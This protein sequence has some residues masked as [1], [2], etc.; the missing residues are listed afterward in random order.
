MLN[1]SKKA[2]PNNDKLLNGRRRERLSEIYYVLLMSV[3]LNKYNNG[4]LPATDGED[5][6]NKIDFLIKKLSVADELDLFFVITELLEPPSLGEAIKCVVNDKSTFNND[7]K[8]RMMLT[9]D[10][11]TNL[12]MR[13]IASGNGKELDAILLFRS[14]KRHT[15]KMTSEEMEYQEHFTGRPDVPKGRNE[16]RKAAHGGLVDY[17]IAHRDH[18]EEKVSIRREQL[19]REKH[20]DCSFE[21]IFYS[22]SSY[23]GD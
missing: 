11:F 8:T 20:E 3:L 7:G 10:K 12:A 2:A 21:P 4:L 16:H 5:S 23:R 9:L 18:V 15:V 14:P 22:K 6:Q 1:T 13:V 17:L 19:D